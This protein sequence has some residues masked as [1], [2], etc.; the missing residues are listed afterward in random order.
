MKKK[1]WVIVP[2][3]IIIISILIGTAILFLTR[4]VDSQSQTSQRFVIPRGQAVRVIADRLQE[5]GL[6]KNALIFQL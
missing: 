5:A 3:L 6:I 1:L 4:P 2:L